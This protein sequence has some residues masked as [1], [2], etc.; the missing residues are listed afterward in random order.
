[1]KFKKHSEITSLAMHRSLLRDSHSMHF[2]VF[3]FLILLIPYFSIGNEAERIRAYLSHPKPLEYYRYQVSDV[4]ESTN[5]TSGFQERTAV[6]QGRWKDDSMNWAQY[7]AKTN[8]GPS[9]RLGTFVGR[10]GS[11]FW[12]SHNGNLTLYSRE[13]NSGSKRTYLVIGTQSHSRANVILRLGF[14]EIDFAKAV[15][16]GLAFEATA[17]RNPFTPIEASWGVVG[18]IS[19]V[20]GKEQYEISATNL[21]TGQLQGKVL[22]TYKG[23]MSEGFFPQSLE[24]VEMVQ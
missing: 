18:L 10:F 6:I 5:S 24:V 19:Q 14:P 20:A 9:D 4:V 13:I 23:P 15:W 11:V 17:T 22:L 8:I 21:V 12:E 3:C 16:K 7:L 2:S 1:M